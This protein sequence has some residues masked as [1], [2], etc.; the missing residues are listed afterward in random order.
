LIFPLGILL[1]RKN[2]VGIG[3]RDTF[4]GTDQREHRLKQAGSQ[5]DAAAF[6]KAASRPV[7]EIFQIS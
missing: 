6:Q 2:F 5:N 3:R 1:D 4:T 7:A